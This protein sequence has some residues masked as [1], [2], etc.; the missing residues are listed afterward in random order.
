[1]SVKPDWRGPSP[2]IENNNSSKA[3][4]QNMKA[5]LSNIKNDFEKLIRKE[6]NLKP[7]HDPLKI[8]NSNKPKQYSS[9]KKD[10][11]STSEY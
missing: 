7:N 11:R 8:V 2:N 10:H 6:I 4:F 1:M 9:A 3:F 5:E